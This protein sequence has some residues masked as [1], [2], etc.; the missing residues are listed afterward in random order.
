MAAQDRTRLTDPPD[1]KIQSGKT[2]G[3]KKEKDRV[4]FEFSAL[5]MSQ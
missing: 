3:E 2:A 4:C 5:C 1:K